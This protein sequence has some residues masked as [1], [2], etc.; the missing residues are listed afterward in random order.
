LIRQLFVHNVMMAMQYA[1]G[2]VIPLL[3]IPH[4]V[5]SIGLDAYG[6]IAIGLSWMTYGMIIVHYAFQLTGP[7]YLASM[8][9]AIAQ[10]ELLVRVYGAKLLLLVIVLS[11]AVIWQLGSNNGLGAHGWLLLTLPLAAGFHAGWYL[12]ARGRFAEVA[13]V[14]IGSSIAALVLGFGWVS[15]NQQSVDSALAALVAGPL[16]AGLGTCLLAGKEIVR[17]MRA[18]RWDRSWLLLRDGWTIF[19]S[20]F[21]AALYGASGA[22]IVGALAGTAAAGA[23]ST[24]ER[25]SNAVIGG[26]LLTHTVAY[27]KLATLYRAERRRYWRLLAV[28]VGMYFLAISLV[29]LCLTLPGISA[30]RLLFGSESD[31]QS[32]LIIC[33]IAWMF[34]GI[35][36]SAV[37]GYL[38]VSGRQGDV[39]PLTTKILAVS[40]LIGV[41]GVAAFGAWAWLASLTLS[42]ALIVRVAWKAVR[43]E[44]FPRGSPG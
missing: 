7:K 13:S 6:R 35:F 28:V 24:V 44:L 32:A 37:T 36:G 3:L 4:I 38:V 40:L 22:I 5:K 12:Q 14:S 29:V 42:Q 23:Y 43:T 1:V 41:P 15:E 30:Q 9:S 18:F 20:Q 17:G 10:S 34:C 16:L 31:D 27:P 39:L 21:S 25:V 19:V 26:A 11:A 33:G 2:G 8:T